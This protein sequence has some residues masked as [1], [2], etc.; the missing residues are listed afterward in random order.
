M[1]LTFIVKV[2]AVSEFN[3]SPGPA[4]MMPARLWCSASQIM[5]EAGGLGALCQVEHGE[6]YHGA[7]LDQ[8]PALRNRKW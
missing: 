4:S 1:F 2:I 7:N 8:F 3:P 5:R 6:F